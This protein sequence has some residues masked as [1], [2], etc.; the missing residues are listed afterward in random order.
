MTASI[1]GGNDLYRLQADEA[2]M[3]RKLLSLW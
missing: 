3:T 2:V 1:D